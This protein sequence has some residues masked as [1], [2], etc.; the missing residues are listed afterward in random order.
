MVSH[1]PPGTPAR[2]CEKDTLGSSPQTQVKGT[3]A[4]R[5]V[6]SETVVF[7]KITERRETV[8]GQTEEVWG[9]RATWCLGWGPGDWK[10]DVGKLEKPKRGLTCA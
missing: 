6:F 10:E 8:P 2:C 5:P 9:P 4:N 7:I 1:K 3:P